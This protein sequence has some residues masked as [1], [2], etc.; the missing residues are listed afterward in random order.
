M[1][2]IFWPFIVGIV[3]LYAVV[4]GLMIHSEREAED[5]FQRAMEALVELRFNG[6]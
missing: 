6:E 2:K 1:L 3:A 4:I 5:Q